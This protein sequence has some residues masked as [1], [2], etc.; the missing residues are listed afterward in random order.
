VISARPPEELLSKRG[1]GIPKNAE[2][3]QSLMRRIPWTSITCVCIWSFFVPLAHADPPQARILSYDVDVSIFPEA[4]LDYAGFIGILYGERPSWNKVDSE[5]AYPHM[6]GESVMEVDFDREPTVSLNV[7]LHSELRVHGIWVDEG[8]AEF[9]QEVVFYPRN[10]SSVATMATVN[11]ANPLSGVHTVKVKYGGMFNPSYSGSPSN[12][13]RI[14]QEGAYLRAFGSSLWFPV[15]VGPESP[16]EQ[17]S[18]R[19]IRVRTPSPYRAVVSG[20]RLSEERAEGFNASEWTVEESSLSGLQLAVRPFE[21]RS[22]HG[23]H[24]F[25]LDHP[26]SASAAEDILAM[27]EKLAAFYGDHYR[28]SDSFDE[29]HVVELPNFASGIS[30]GNTIG[31]TSGQ[32]RGFSLT[33][34]DTALERLVAHEL[35]HSFVRPDVGEESPLAALFIEGFPSYFHLPALEQMLGEEWYLAYLQRVEERYLEKRTTG[36]TPWGSRLPEEKPI[37]AITYQEIGEYKDTFIL[38]DRVLLFLHDLRRRIGAH[39]FKAMTRELMRTVGLTPDGFMDLIER[40]I[41]GSRDDLRIW[42]E[43]VDYPEHLRL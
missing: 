22:R 33:D 9:T 2:Q 30:A 29:T 32:W 16:D 11:L 25:F 23:I 34:E 8:P 13:M 10:Y 41:P 35:V 43:T 24:L 1:S 38:S 42:L 12:Y 36:R 18:F 39:E 40:F 4:R 19:R 37:L 28:S 3:E 6:T 20:R 31:I 21:E 15:L 7:Y 17:T 26:G 27:V 14:D 5:K